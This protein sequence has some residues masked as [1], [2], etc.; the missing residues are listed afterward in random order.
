M[1]IAEIVKLTAAGYKVS[2]ITELKGMEKDNPE[3][4]NLAL[5]GNSFSDVKDLLALADA[6]EVNPTEA[7]DPAPGERDPEPDYKSMYEELKKKSDTLENTIKEI[8]KSNQST[9]GDPQKTDEE[10]ITELVQSFM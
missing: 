10:I 8:Q 2:E 5:N 3:A 9:P 1:N 7:P 4:L 6:E